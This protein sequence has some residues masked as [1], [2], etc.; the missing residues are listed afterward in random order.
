MSQAAQWATPQPTIPSRAVSLTATWLLTASSCWAGPIWLCPTAS[1]PCTDASSQ[2][3][4]QGVFGEHL[5]VR[6]PWI[7]LSVTWKCLIRDWSNPDGNTWFCRTSPLQL[8][9]FLAMAVTSS[10]Q[11]MGKN[12]MTEIL[13]KGRMFLTLRKQSFPSPTPVILRSWWIL[14]AESAYLQHTRFQPQW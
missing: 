1:T 14:L 3:R 13:N 9:P 4:Q 10:S 6:T 2:G 12:R 5:L 8:L 11:Q 7:S